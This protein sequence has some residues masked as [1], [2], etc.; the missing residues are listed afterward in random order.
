VPDL[1]PAES[2]VNL[3]SLGAKGDGVADDTA[4]LKDAIAKH[5]AIYLPSGKYRVT[6][7]ISLK[8][9]TVLIGLNPITTQI[10]ISDW[11][12]AFMGAPEPE[13]P[14]GRARRFGQPFPGGPKPLLETPKNGTNI[15]T[16]IGLDT[17]GNNPAAVG[18]LWMA[19]AKSMM[20]DVKYLGGHGSGAG[21]IY[22]N[23][24]SGDPSPERRWDCQ[25]PSLWVA[26]GGGGTF[27]NIWT[28]SPFAQSGMT[29]TDTTTEGRVYQMSSEHHVRYEVQI[30]NAS[31]WSLI[32]LQTE[33]ER[34]E[35]PFCLPLEIENSNNITIANLN[36]YRVV[37]MFQPFPYAV[38]VSDSKDI[39]FRGVHCYSN[40]KVSYDNLLYDQSA[41]VEVRQREFAWLTLTGKT[42]KRETD[43]RVE[44]L[45]S[46][47]FN[48]SGGAV[49]PKGDFYFVDSRWQK[50]YRW[51]SEKRQAMVVQ[52]SPTLPI[53]LVFD[54]A[55]NLMVI[56]SAGRGTVY[57]FKPGSQ[58]PI[59]LLKPEPSKPRPGLTAVF[60]VTD[61]MLNDA[62]IKGTS[63]QRPFHYVSPDGATFIPAGQ[64]F[65]DG[66]LTWGVKLQ[67][68]IRSFGLAK[69]TAGKP[70]Y[71]TAES[72]MRTYSAT[73]EP[74]GTVTNA[75]LFVEQGG[76]GLAVDGQGN[77]YL[78]AGQIYVYSPAG[79]LID[80]IE[81]PERPTQ[82]MFGGKD[83]KTLFITA[84]T[85]LYSVGIK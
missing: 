3:A 21:Q 30:R 23:N 32:A 15:V 12:P 63:L 59:Q 74:D 66:A 64:D 34:G 4:A 25:Y 47:F 19:G 33:A 8:P 40:S 9:D 57:T 81:V 75:K 67:D 43:A 85:S 37:S 35:S 56:S 68:I 39:H 36:I 54:Q 24:N 76:E 80:T 72:D 38:K 6:D 61:W 22:N 73:I 65:V 82:L 83:G 49:D 53:N 11:T 13:P 55:G 28:A 18:T 10:V 20:D 29:I 51:D 16:G 52:D 70:F 69:T 45:A 48:I 77:V 84:R 62:L 27:K 78:A 60:P 31:N 26:N 14:A 1:P 41:N 44:K 79:Q 58:D 71:F 46:G 50:I 7:T 17:G 5:K 42:P 2:W